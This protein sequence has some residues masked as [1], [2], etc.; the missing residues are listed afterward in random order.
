MRPTR[1]LALKR[2]RL[3]A[4]GDADLAAVNGGSHLCTVGHG[5]SFDTPC[6]LTQPINQCLSLPDCEYEFTRIVDV[7]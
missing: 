6:N 1:A 5:A 3:T 4:L 7:C 2:E